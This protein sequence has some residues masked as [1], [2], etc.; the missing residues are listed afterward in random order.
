MKEKGAHLVDIQGN[1]VSA[2]LRLGGE[3]GCLLH[4]VPVSPQVGQPEV[5]VNKLK[6][7]TQKC[8]S[9][10]ILLDQT[11]AVGRM[12]QLPFPSTKVNNNEPLVLEGIN[13]MKHANRCS[14]K[15]EIDVLSWVFLGNV[16]QGLQENIRASD[17]IIEGEQP[18]TPVWGFCGFKDI[19]S[20]PYSL[21][22]I[23]FEAVHVVA[24]TDTP[25]TQEL[26]QV[27]FHRSLHKDKVVVCHAETEVDKNT[28]Q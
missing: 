19:R 26:Q 13:V 22:L 21:A 9:V 25:G 11:N 27:D 10:L 17:E 23:G 18:K 3:H 1:D 24:A 7:A 20:A 2:H 5:V 16:E 8:S 6:A 15:L 12:L 28:K 4:L 14:F